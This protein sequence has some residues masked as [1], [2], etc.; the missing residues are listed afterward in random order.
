MV[1]I[2]CGTLNDIDSLADLRFDLLKAVGN[3]NDNTDIEELRKSSIDYFER[4]IDNG[5]LKVRKFIK[6]RLGLE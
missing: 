2:R 3:I 6:F 1:K 5:F 4:K